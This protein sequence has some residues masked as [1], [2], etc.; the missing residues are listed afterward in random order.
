MKALTE[1][2][3]HQS[4]TGANQRVFQENEIYKFTSFQ[5]C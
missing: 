5:F 3:F 1:V 2:A 4:R